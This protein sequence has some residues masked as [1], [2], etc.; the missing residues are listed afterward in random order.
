[1]SDAEAL[2][3]MRQYAE[4]PPIDKRVLLQPYLKEQ[5]RKILRIV[6]TN[7]SGKHA[8]ID[9]TSLIPYKDVPGDQVAILDQVLPGVAFILSSVICRK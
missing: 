1:M 7:I 9:E 6:R 5:A 3:F 8:S 4:W 2:T